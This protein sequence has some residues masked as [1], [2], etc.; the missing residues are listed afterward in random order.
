MKTRKKQEL[1]AAT[2]AIAMAIPMAA[3]A[4]QGAKHPW[5]DQSLSP[6]ERARLVAKEMTLDEKIA[7][8][9]GQGMPGEREGL[10][11][12]N[13]G[14]GFSIG[15]PR[16][17]IPPI[18]MADAAYGVTRSAANGRY[19]TALPNNLGAAASWDKDSALEYGKLIAT[20]L[21]DQGYNMTL[22]GGVNLTREPRNGR[23]FE[24]M[25]EDPLLAGTLDGYV[26][27]GEQSEHVIGDIKH[28]AINDQESGRNAVN[29]N[30]DE[31]SM[32]ESDLLAFEI[33]LKVSDADAVMCSYNRVN[34]VYACENDYLLHDVLKGAF[35]FP[36]FVT[37]DWGGTHSAVQASHAGLDMEQPDE[38]YYGK[39][40][41][42]AVLAGK[43]SQAELDDHVVRILR[44]EFKEGI[45]DHPA[46]KGVVN[47]NHGNQVAQAIEEKSIVLLKNKGGILP[48]DASQ[49]K[50]IAII[51]G[52]A[53]AGVLSG[54]GSGQVDAPGGTPV[55]P[56]PG[57]G[58]F[59]AFIKQQYL[60]D[61][62]LDAIR[63]AY[64]NAKV[65]FNSGEDV[66]AAA[67]LAKNSDVAIVFGTQWAAESFDLKTLSLSADQNKLIEAV[68][69]ANPKNVVVIESG[70]PVLMPW[71]DKAGAVVEAWFSG[72]RGAEAL[73]EVIDGT[74]NPSG[75][76]P[77]TFPLS[78]ADLPHP[79]LVQP[80]PASDI[81]LK[82][83]MSMTDVMKELGEGLPAFQTTYD[84][85]LKVG[86]KWYDAEKKDVLF[87]FG[88]GLS[89]TQF[90][91]SDLKA[92]HGD[93]VTVSFDVKNT[94]QRDGDEIAQVYA[95]LPASAGEPPHRLVGWARLSIKAG[96]TQKATVTIDRQMLSVFDTATH[97]WKLVPGT[98]TLYAGASSRDLPLKQTIE[99]R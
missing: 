64:P 22:G 87:P 41:K 43:V 1:A 90:A 48:L 28:Y 33:A 82:P 67:E 75:K 8:V 78:D 73:T 45:V 42:D 77:V 7:L 36:G 39:P 54:G 26:M 66:H 38:F 58:I 88:F 49:V 98:Y 89:Y 46:D 83:G 10:S 72:I 29:A 44:A 60:R 24:Y 80:P 34:G 79:T 18:Q 13:G 50:S 99:L 40:L 86:Y 84:E 69:A 71:V 5:D 52:H 96:E 85:K 12:G 57:E 97:S 25:G 92:E 63:K 81:Q 70:N 27:R 95:E 61:V 17:G 55:P 59:A 62:P 4:Q 20:E 65:E 93:T 68:T 31:R 3:M 94:G 2:L 30:I 91:Y 53:D 35:K 6:T 76:L 56:P 47:V 19:G 11:L 21:K 74:V 23:T 9:H 37:S 15:V 51:G 32:R 16:L 14:A